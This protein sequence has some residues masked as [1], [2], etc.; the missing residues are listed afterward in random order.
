MKQVIEFTDY[1]C[2]P[3]LIEHCES[4][5]IVKDQ[6]MFNFDREYRDSI[7]NLILEN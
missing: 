2:I 5:T 7:Y 3:G 1:K 4:R 6:F